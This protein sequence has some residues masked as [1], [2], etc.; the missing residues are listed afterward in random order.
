V[1]GKKTTVILD[2]GVRRGSDI[3][4]ALAL[5][6]TAVLTGR[7]TLYGI[8]SSDIFLAMVSGTCWGQY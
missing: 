1:V 4:K 8:S 6:A 2:S 3:V 7:A 5:G